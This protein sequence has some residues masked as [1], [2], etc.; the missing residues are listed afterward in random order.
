MSISQLS[1]S[2][3]QEASAASQETQPS[4][5]RSKTDRCLGEAAGGSNGSRHQS[6][7]PH[8]RHLQRVALGQ[9]AGELFEESR[10]RDLLVSFT[11]KSS[12]DVISCKDVQKTQIGMETHWLRSKLSGADIQQWRQRH[13]RFPYRFHHHLLWAQYRLHSFIKNLHRPLRKGVELFPILCFM[14]HLKEKK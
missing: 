8:G 12:Q 5:C 9:Q 6:A 4:P 3:L 14:S 7:S 10:V 13:R 2:Y 1:M 11:P